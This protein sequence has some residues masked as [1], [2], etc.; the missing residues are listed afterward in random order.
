MRLGRVAVFAAVL[1]AAQSHFAFACKPAR[2]DWVVDNVEANS[3]AVALGEVQSVN[4]NWLAGFPWQWEGVATVKITKVL[5]GRF[6][7]S[8]FAPYGNRLFVCENRWD[9]SIG[10]KVKVYI[11][12]RD[13]NMWIGSGQ[14][15]AWP[16]DD[17]E[18]A[19]KYWKS[20]R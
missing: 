1:L 11:G 6:P 16:L 5:K 2:L 12:P 19:R 7:G 4:R 10:K 9:A 18:Y 8:V 14:V 17:I 15:M 20:A 3:D 13:G